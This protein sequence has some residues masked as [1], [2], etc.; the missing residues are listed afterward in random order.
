MF[1]FFKYCV[2]PFSGNTSRLRGADPQREGKSGVRIHRNPGKSPYSCYRTDSCGSLTCSE[3]SL[4]I[5]GTARLTSPSD[6]RRYWIFFKV[7]INATLITSPLH[8]L[9]HI[10]AM[11]CNSLEEYSHVQPAVE[12]VFFFP[13]SLLMFFVVVVVFFSQRITRL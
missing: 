12:N 7:V 5:H 10:S 3:D 8:R 13:F 9:K 11:D 1:C 4:T 6:G 2:T